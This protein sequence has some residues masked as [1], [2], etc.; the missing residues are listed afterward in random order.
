MHFP[1][2]VSESIQLI[3]TITSSTYTTFSSSLYYFSIIAMKLLLPAF[4]GFMTASTAV[5]AYSDY[6]VYERDLDYDTLYERDLDLDGGL[7]ERNF[8]EFESELLYRRELYDDLLHKRGLYHD[9]LNRLYA[10]GKTSGGTGSFNAEGSL[11]V[12]PRVKPG[13]PVNDDSKFPGRGQ[14]LDGGQVPGLPRLPEGGRTN[15]PRFPGQGHTPGS[16]V[17]P[18]LS[19]IPSIPSSPGNSRPGTPGKARRR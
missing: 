16:P 1:S 10:R 13:Q 8:Q 18:P 11:N 12:N 7:H 4:L 9:A 15:D 6:G 3:F 17:M 5:I 2:K 14:R 19:E